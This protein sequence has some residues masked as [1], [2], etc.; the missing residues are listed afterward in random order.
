MECDQITRTPAARTVSG[1][2]SA[3]VS[4]EVP[5]AVYGRVPSTMPGGAAG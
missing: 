5:A 1:G 3:A 4:G 2:V